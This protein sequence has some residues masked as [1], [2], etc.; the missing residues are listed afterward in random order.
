MIIRKFIKLRKF[1]I[2]DGV[3]T[4]N[5]EGYGCPQAD[6]GGERKLKR[7]NRELKEMGP[8]A[9]GGEQVLINDER[10]LIIDDWW[11]MTDCLHTENAE[12]TE[13]RR[14]T[15]WVNGNCHQ[16]DS[17]WKKKFFLIAVILQV[18][19]V[20]EKELVVCGLQLP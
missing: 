14:R 2:I 6:G 8:Q 7:I 11:L 15:L 20:Q 18:I 9:D 17:N 12:D 5:T 3:H 4:E 19:A 10:L 13:V 16:L 1:L